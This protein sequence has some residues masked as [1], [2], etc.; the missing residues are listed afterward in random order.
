MVTLASE[1]DTNTTPNASEDVV[2]CSMIL[3]V[4]RGSAQSSAF[5]GMLTGTRTSPRL[6]IASNGPDVK[7][8]S[9]DSVYTQHYTSLHII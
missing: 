8:S 6:K 3:K 2:C 5:V 9:T 1:G 7:S 4:S